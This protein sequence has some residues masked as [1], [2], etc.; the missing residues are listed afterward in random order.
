VLD[1]VRFAPREHVAQNGIVEHLRVEEFLETVQGLVS[2]SM[3][4]ER[5]HLFA[6]FL[7]L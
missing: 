5:L 7:E 3:F 2:A 6:S 4:I 1:V